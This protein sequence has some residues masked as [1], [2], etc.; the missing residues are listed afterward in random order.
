LTKNA[1]MSKQKNV[2]NNAK[3]IKTSKLERTSHK[4]VNDL[5]PGCK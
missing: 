1:E 3:K 5:E 2:D 4:T